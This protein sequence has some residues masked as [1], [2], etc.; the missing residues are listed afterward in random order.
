MGA[1]ALM[2]DLRPELWRKP[3]G[4]QRQRRRHGLI[5]SASPEAAPHNQQSQRAMALGSAL[6]GTRKPGKCGAHRVTQQGHRRLQRVPKTQTQKAPQCPTT[7]P[8]ERLRKRFDDATCN[9]CKPTIREPGNRI[10]F[11]Q[12]KRDAH[13]TC[14]RAAGYGDIAPHSQNDQRADPPQRLERL[15]HPPNEIERQTQQREPPL[16]AQCPKTNWLKWQARPLD[17]ACLHP[18]GVPQPMNLPASGTQYFGDGEARKH[19]AARSTRHHHG[20]TDPSRNLRR[21]SRAPRIRR[22]FS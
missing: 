1:P 21:H 22:L 2:N 11:V 17:Q 6:G 20:G 8:L 19:M 3:L 5:Q 10:L 15:R 16:A 4:Q 18:F 14:G 12:N 13:E 9:P 7:R